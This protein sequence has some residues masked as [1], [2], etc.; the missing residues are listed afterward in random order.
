[1]TLMIILS[2]MH[3]AQPLGWERKISTVSVWCLGQ[4]APSS[5]V[6]FSQKNDRFASV[7]CSLCVLQRCQLQGEGVS[8]PHISGN[9]REQAKHWDWSSRARAETEKAT[10]TGRDSALEQVGMRAA[11]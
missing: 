4:K 7:S 8:P 11:V 1:M 6:P 3:V 10:T 2:V 5:L 9:C